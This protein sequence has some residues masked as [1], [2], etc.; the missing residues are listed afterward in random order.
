M[1]FFC[2]RNFVVQI[3]VYMNWLPQNQCEK[4]AKIIPKLCLFLSGISST[5]TGQSL[6]LFE[7]FIWFDWLKWKIEFRTGT[8]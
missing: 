8:A 2:R 3:V 7:S 6:S 1:F 4:L 5:W